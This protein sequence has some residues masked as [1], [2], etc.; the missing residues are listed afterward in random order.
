MVV[1]DTRA[2][3]RSRVT[4]RGPL[5]SSALCFA[6]IAVCWGEVCLIVTTFKC[7]IVRL[8]AHIGQKGGEF[9]PSWINVDP[10][11]ASF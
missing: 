1:E 5:A 10:Q 4:D 9:F 7:A 11:C 6:P 3:V 2:D 8:F